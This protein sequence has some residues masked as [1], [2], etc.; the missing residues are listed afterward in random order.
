MTP[1][2]SDGICRWWEVSLK[3]TMPTNPYR[4]AIFIP[5][6]RIWLTQ[7]GLTRHTPTDATDFKILTNFQGP[8]WVRD[9]VFYQIFPERFADGDPSNNVKSGE[10][11]RHGVASIARQWGELPYKNKAAGMEFFG[12]DLQGITHHLDYLQ[13]LGV[14]ALY[15]NP[16]FLSPSNHKYDTMDYLQIDPHFGGDAALI[17]LRRALDER[18]MRMILDIAPN[19]CSSDHPW[20]REAQGNLTA[21][22]A[23][24]FTFHQHPDQYESW[25][26]HRTLVKLNYRSENLREQMYSG[27]NGVMRYWLRNPFGVDGWRVDVAN[28]LAR[29]GEQQFAHKIG[30]GMRRAIKAE[31][32]D[33]YLMGENFYDGTPHLQGDE[34]DAVMNYE[35]FM[36]PLL[37][38]LRDFA[39]EMPHMPDWVDRHPLPTDIVAEQWQAWRAAIPWQIAMQQFNLIDSHDTMRA[40]SIL[41]ENEAVFR[42]AV[43]VLFTFP[44]V[45]SVYYGDEIGMS[46]LGDPDNRRCMIWDESQW[47][48]SLR[49][50][51]KTLI[52][53]RLNSPALRWGG[54]QQLYAEGDTLAYQRETR[55][56]RLI[57]VARR[58][59]D[60]LEAIPV[61]HG[62]I[63]D[64]AAFREL[65]T[66][67]EVTISGGHLPLIGLGAPGAQIWQSL[68]E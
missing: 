38:W 35:G 2:E 36:L 45:P 37:H 22:S 50:Y 14:T 9:T 26:G 23:E 39:I 63:P 44:G 46:G 55:D 67:T 3:L 42:L 25:L 49:D 54:F 12:G 68:A 32:P 60:G 52:R 56:E 62:G 65:F 43:A 1:A 17:E 21:P 4:F 64:G 58:H 51:Y 34:L 18:G 29:Q 13:D 11:T 40:F 28:M 19:H 16:I 41:N 10:I 31:H 59:A 47:N 8:S 53:L 61:R 27:T 20:F 66:G 7:A 6:G 30:R 48:G 24:Y 33:A 5:E 57:L 15:L